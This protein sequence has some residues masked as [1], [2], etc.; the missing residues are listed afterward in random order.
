MSAVPPTADLQP[1]K[2]PTLHERVR[3]DVRVPALVDSDW[4]RLGSFILVHPKVNGRDI[5]WFILDSGASGCTITGDAARRAGAVEIGTTLIQASAATTVYRC[6]SL[7]LGPMRFE[8]LHIT[9]L[10]MER[11][12]QVFGHP[13]AGI[14]G[15]NVFESAIVVLNGPTRSVHF[16]DPAAPNAMERAE[17]MARVSSPGFRAGMDAGAIEWIPLALRRELPHVPVRFDGENEASFILDTGADATIH[18]FDDTV[19]RHALLESQGVRITGTKTQVT[20]GQRASI[21]DGVI[22]DLRLGAAQV[23]PCSASFARPGDGVS[24]HLSE[25]AG[26]VGMGIMREFVVVVDEPGSRVAF[27]GGSR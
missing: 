21:S 6:D 14:L 15:R 4:G 13:I 23:G 22:E 24:K 1:V 3:F 20:F 25:S 9:G 27:I 26:L 18:F 11:S 19:E 16:F 10:D 8:G 17:T 5:G 2:D 12:M 7:E